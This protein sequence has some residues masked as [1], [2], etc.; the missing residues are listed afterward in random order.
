LTEL[1][2][3]SSIALTWN[4]KPAPS[5]FLHKQ[6]DVTVATFAI[7]IPLGTELAFGRE[8]TQGFSQAL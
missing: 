5:M 7:D 4:G 3:P 1:S 8:N 6:L 2:I